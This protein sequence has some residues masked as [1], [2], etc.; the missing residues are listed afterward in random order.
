MKTLTKV[1]DFFKTEI[2]DSLDKASDYLYINEYLIHVLAGIIKNDPRPIF[3]HADKF[4]AENKGKGDGYIFLSDVP[5]PTVIP[6]RAKKVLIGETIEA[7]FADIGSN[8][9]Y[10]LIFAAATPGEDFDVKFTV[11]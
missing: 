11:I 1:A 6:A 8:T 10:Y 4:K 7:P 2:I 3:K 5:N 9:E